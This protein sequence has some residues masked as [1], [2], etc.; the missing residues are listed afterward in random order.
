MGVL[1]VPAPHCTVAEVS[2]A[3][4]HREAPT[5]ICSHLS[6]RL[7]GVVLTAD[8][9]PWLTLRHLPSTNLLTPL[10]ADASTP[11]YVRRF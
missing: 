2:E 6:C 10:V 1:S 5:G 9:L 3:E 4:P 7:S 11:Q 8:V